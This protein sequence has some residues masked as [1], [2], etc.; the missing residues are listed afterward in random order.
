MHLT[1]MDSGIQRPI[2]HAF[3]GRFGMHLTAD[4]ACI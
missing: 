1:A 3:N 2:W 4:L